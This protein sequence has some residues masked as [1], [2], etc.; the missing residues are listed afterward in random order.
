M[1]IGDSIKVW[2]RT[3]TKSENGQNL[4]EI[5]EIRPYTGPYKEFTHIVKLRAP[6][7]KNGWLEM[8]VNETDIDL[9]IENRN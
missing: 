1:K 8:T 2:W 6:S 4:A 3:F 9:E 7:T 5:L